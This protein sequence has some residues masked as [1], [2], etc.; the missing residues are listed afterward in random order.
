MLIERIERHIESR[1]VCEWIV[2][3]FVPAR[4]S[5]CGLTLLGRS[6]NYF[7]VPTENGSCITKT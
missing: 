5:I 7:Q 4:I 6:R 3:G 1:Q 2:S